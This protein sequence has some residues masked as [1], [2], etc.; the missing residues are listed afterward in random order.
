MVD[1]NSLL[2]VLHRQRSA[3]IETDGAEARL[4]ATRAGQL[5]TI[6]WKQELVMAG[7]VWRV[8]VGTITAG[9][10]VSLVTGGG[11]G[12][13]IDQD[14]PEAAIGVDAGYFLIP[15]E[16]R[17]SCQVDL[18]A[19]AE[20]GDIIVAVDRSAGVP[21]T[22]T[23]SVE[24]PVNQLDG[25]EAFPGRAFS[26]ITVDITDPTVDEILDYQTVRAAEFVSN[27][28][29]T[30]LTNGIVVPL[31]MLYQPQVPN[32]IA[33]PCGIYVYWGGTAAVPGIATILVA[34]VEIARYSA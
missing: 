16:V 18:D 33:G 31:R 13:T 28:I 9:G 5:T 30:N 11:A 23:G 29:A 7:K 24:T 1:V 3:A 6:N 21:T 32:L 8:D 4:R 15:L 25:A 34:A 17:V 12:T 10:D 14:Q 22:V 27:G 2:K 26:A 19:N 20:V